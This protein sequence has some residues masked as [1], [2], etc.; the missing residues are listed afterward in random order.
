MALRTV[1]ESDDDEED[2]SDSC[3]LRLFLF[4]F[5]C[6]FRFENLCLCFLSLELRRFFFSECSDLFLLPSLES[7]DDLFRLR[8]EESDDKMGLR[9]SCFR[10]CLR[11]RGERDR[12][13]PRSLDRRSRWLCHNK[14]NI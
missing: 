3:L 12:C 8:D 14:V 7:D 6:S 10:L 4:F 1:S 13:R 9:R 11:S 2:E 5:L